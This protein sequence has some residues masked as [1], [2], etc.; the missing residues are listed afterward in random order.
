MKQEKINNYARWYCNKYLPSTEQCRQKITRKYKWL[1]NEEVRICIEIMIKER[2]LHDTHLIRSRIEQYR[3]LWRSDRYIKQKLLI[4]RFAHTDIQ[5]QLEVG[6][7][8]QWEYYKPRIQTIIEQHIRRLYG[9]RYLRMKLYEYWFK[10]EISELL[11]EF[12]H[13]F[14]EASISYKKLLISK[15]KDHKK[16]PGLMYS[17]GF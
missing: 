17:R 13:E 7:D 6:V 1:T 9:E 4:K 12:E 8:S 11:Q 14:L 16:I 2:F 3:N 15:W 10:D 5:T